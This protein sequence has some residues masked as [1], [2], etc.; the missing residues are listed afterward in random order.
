MV[1]GRLP[2]AAHF[3]HAAIA[4]GNRNAADELAGS[5]P[6]LLILVT[7][8]ESKAVLFSCDCSGG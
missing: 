2:G 5:S 3:L 4:I 8:G 1:A 6:L 7:V